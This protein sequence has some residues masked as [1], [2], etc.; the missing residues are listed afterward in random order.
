MIRQARVKVKLLGASYLKGERVKGVMLGAERKRVTVRAR[1][2]SRGFAEQAAAL[3]VELENAERARLG[4]DPIGP[5]DLIG[6]VV[7]EEIYFTT[8]R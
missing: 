8:L 2:Y 5:E 6:V 3:A 7:G 1:D 4:L